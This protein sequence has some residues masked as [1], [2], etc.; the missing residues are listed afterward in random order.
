MDAIKNALQAA[1]PAAFKDA[2]MTLEAALFTST[3]DP[4]IAQT[5]AYAVAVSRGNKTLAAILAQGLP[6]DRVEQ[7][8]VAAAIMGMTNVYYSYI[9]YVGLP[10]LKSL[11]AQIRMVSYGQQ[12]GR[13]KVGFEVAT[14]AVSIAGRC[15]SC[16]SAHASE[17][18]KHGFTDENFRDVGRLAAAVNSLANIV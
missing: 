18:Q 7:G 1:V 6:E 14:L 12:A 17:L 3:I 16:I 8:N 9:D 10:G 11:P 13:D 5:S 2:R 4:A 15:K